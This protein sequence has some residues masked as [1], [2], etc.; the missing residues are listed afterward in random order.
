MIEI[1]AL[2]KTYQTGKRAV[3]ALNGINVVYHLLR[4]LV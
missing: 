2:A 4:R 3:N 1:T